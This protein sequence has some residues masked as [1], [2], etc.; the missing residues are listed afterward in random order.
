MPAT[1]E[2]IWS[3]VSSIF[4]VARNSISSSSSPIPSKKPITNERRRE[5]ENITIVKMNIPFPS[6]SGVVSEFREARRVKNQQG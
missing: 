1:R 3:I 5:M 6:F 2:M 4:A